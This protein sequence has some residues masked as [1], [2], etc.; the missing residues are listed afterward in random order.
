MFY[1]ISRIVLT[2]SVSLN[3]TQLPEGKGV[4][5]QLF[6]GYDTFLTSTHV[7]IEGM[8]IVSICIVRTVEKMLK[9]NG[10]KSKYK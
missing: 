4:P 5:L 1:S 6:I 8:P 10:P 3:G 2:L 9:I 7:C